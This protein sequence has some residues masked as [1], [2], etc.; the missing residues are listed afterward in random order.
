MGCLLCE[1]KIS[2]KTS[3]GKIL[4]SFFDGDFGTICRLYIEEIIKVK[5]FNYSLFSFQGKL[6]YLRP[7]HPCGVYLERSREKPSDKPVG[8]R[9]QGTRPSGA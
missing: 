2:K 4:T 9:R 5:I 8:S 7:P 6:P 3:Q 1:N